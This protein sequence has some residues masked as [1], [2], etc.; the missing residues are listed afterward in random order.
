MIINLYFSWKTGSNFARKYF[1]NLCEISN[2]EHIKITD[3]NKPKTKHNNYC[4]CLYRIPNEKHFNKNTTEYNIIQLRD[5]RD[6]LVSAYY[7]M[8]YTHPYGARTAE[9]HQAVQKKNID[10]FII[11]NYK[12][13]LKIFEDTIKIS[14]QMNNVD[15]V[16]YSMM[17]LN[18]EEWVKQTTKHFNI[19][20]QQ[21]DK[22]FKKYKNEFE[23]IKE[24][25]ENELKL[26]DTKNFDIKYHKRKVIPGDYKQKLKS[27]T[28]QLLNE[29]F[30]N[31]LDFM[32]SKNEL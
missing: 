18:F 28:I 10:N 5:P 4:V 12:T 25:T 24:I 1:K 19:T 30:I 14:K 17:V 32:K 26:I 9:I 22:L 6:V 31:I 27:S 11:E 23:N 7:S 16:N 21:K 2:I 8:A 15:F 29:K 3:N 13:T 20:S